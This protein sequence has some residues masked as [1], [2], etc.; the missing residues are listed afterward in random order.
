MESDIFIVEDI[1][2]EVIA[3]LGG[4]FDLDLQFF[5]DHIDNS[6]WYC[7]GDI[8]KHLPALKSAKVE[9]QFLRFQF[10]SPRE[11]IL[12]ELIQVVGDRIELDLA[13][14][15]VPRVGGAFDPTERG[16]G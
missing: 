4:R 10:V 5:L 8:E 13:S 2:P 1:N 9:S 15:R 6:R 12:K 14:T 11:S 7:L 16:G 3:F